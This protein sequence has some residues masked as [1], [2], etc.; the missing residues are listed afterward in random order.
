MSVNQILADLDNY[1]P[2][3]LSE[4]TV[5]AIKDALRAG[6]EMRDKFDVFY[7]ARD[8]LYFAT[9]VDFVGLGESGKSWDGAVKGD[10]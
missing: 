6:Q 3:S 5:K 2:F 10:V 7:D 4:E 1:Q 8:G 9:S